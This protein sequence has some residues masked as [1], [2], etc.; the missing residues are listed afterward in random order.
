MSSEID[1]NGNHFKADDYAT[2]FVNDKFVN[3]GNFT[4][5]TASGVPRRNVFVNNSVQCTNNVDI[6]SNDIA[7]NNL[8]SN[9]FTDT[10]DTDNFKR[11]FSGTST[12]EKG[13]GW[14][15]HKLTGGPINVS[16]NY[17]TLFEQLHPGQ[18]LDEGA[19]PVYLVIE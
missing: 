5:G 17:K 4:A 18:T 1:M 19:N 8:F 10:G 11:N 2:N 13:V 9:G 14:I 6:S 15:Y 7:Y 12:N 16:V 3:V